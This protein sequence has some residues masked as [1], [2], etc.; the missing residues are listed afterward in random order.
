MSAARDRSKPEKSAPQGS[1]ETGDE[2]FV[3]APDAFTKARDEG[4]AR[5]RAAGDRAGTTRIKALHRPT[6]AASPSTA[7]PAPTPTR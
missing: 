7:S 4:S 3:L 1:D 2:L 5:A 6:A